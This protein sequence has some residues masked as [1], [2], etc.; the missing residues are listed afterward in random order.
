LAGADLPLE[1]SLIMERQ[2]FWLMFDTADQK[3]GMRAFIEK[4][5]PAFTGK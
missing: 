2:A 5:S 1:A 3:E 4:R